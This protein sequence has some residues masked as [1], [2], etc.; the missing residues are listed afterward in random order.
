M[1]NQQ[2]VSNNVVGPKMNVGV[3]QNNFGGNNEIDQLTKDTMNLKNNMKVISKKVEIVI[4]I[5]YT[6]EDGSTKVVTQ[7]ESHEFKE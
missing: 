6:Y 2:L 4:K 1:L 3:P 7:N 5:T